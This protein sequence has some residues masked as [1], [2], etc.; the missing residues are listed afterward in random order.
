MRG[1]RIKNRVKNSESQMKKGEMEQG[2]EARRTGGSQQEG[3]GHSGG[4]SVQ[5]KLRRSEQSSPLKA[6]E[7]S[8]SKRR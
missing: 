3:R 1:R 7:V 4:M 2:E 8:R 5:G 6:A